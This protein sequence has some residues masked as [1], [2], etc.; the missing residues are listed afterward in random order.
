MR[1]YYTIKYS[2]KWKYINTD[3]N[4]INGLQAWITDVVVGKHKANHIQPIIKNIGY[5]VY[6]D[7][8]FKIPYPEVHHAQQ[9][10]PVLVPMLH[11]V[12]FEVTKTV[13]KT[14][15]KKVPTPV[16]KIV[17]VPVEKLVP[18]KVIKHVPVLVD[19]KIPIKIPVYKTIHHKVH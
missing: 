2:P 15:E 8:E 14:V 12:P 3:G 7:V 10:Y 18:F 19:K 16:E 5:P 11:P 17:P 13:V 9:P 6:K 4:S 1:V